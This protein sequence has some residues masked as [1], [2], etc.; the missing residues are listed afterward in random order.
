ML[1][2]ISFVYNDE[3]NLKSI[4]LPIKEAKTT[5]SLLLREVSTLR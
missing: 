3:G 1:T 4:A 2:K 5:D